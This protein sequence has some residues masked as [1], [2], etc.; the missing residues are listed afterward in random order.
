MASKAFQFMWKAWLSS[1]LPRFISSMSNTAIP[2][3]PT[4]S[5]QPNFLI[6]ENAEAT[7]KHLRRCLWDCVSCMWITMGSRKSQASASE[8]FLRMLG[9][10]SLSSDHKAEP[11]P[12]ASVAGSCKRQ[13]L[14]A[15]HFPSY[16]IILELWKEKTA[17]E[18][19][20]MITFSLIT[21]LSKFCMSSSIWPFQCEEKPLS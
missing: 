20:A 6:N 2:Y 14:R 18:M 21:P 16:F 5:H 8:G 17:L 1:L 9:P 19:I 10:T 15:S 13:Q 11:L 4:S 3:L 12:V 7:H